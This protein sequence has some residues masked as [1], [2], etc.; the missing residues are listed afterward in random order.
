MTSKLQEFKEKLFK[1]LKFL[2]K[3]FYWKKKIKNIEKL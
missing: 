1:K 3:K 2:I